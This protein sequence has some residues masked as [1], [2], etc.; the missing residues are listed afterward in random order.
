MARVFSGS[1]RVRRLI[2]IEMT[3]LATESH[4]GCEDCTEHSS[5]GSRY[6][7][8]LELQFFQFLFDEKYW[9]Y[10]N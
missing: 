5:V 9:S 6:G 4:D 3:E 1:E 2:K 8:N 10:Q 7:S